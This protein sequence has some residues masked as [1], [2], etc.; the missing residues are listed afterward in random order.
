MA[1]DFRY[2]IR[3][4][5]DLAAQVAQ[6]A[7]IHDRSF[8]RELIRA[9][10]LWTKQLSDPALQEVVEARAHL[11]ELTS[12]LS[13]AGVQETI[14]AAAQPEVQQALKRAEA[15]GAT[16]AQISASAFAR[17]WDSDEDRAYDDLE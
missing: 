7:E 8:N 9:A 2:T 17:D 13:D 15:I 10:E 14:K 12:R 4:P 16:W 6:L 5:A 3:M 11:A 1:N